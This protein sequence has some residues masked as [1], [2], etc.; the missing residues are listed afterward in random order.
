MAEVWRVNGILALRSHRG[1]RGLLQGQ[2]GSLV[3]G[4]DKGR[5]GYEAQPNHR[6][7]A[8]RQA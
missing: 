6:Y 4:R 7:L 3:T 2:R 5:N 8:P 1:R